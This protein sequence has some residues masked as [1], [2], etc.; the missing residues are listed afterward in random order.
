MST[1]RGKKATDA[2]HPAHRAKRGPAASALVATQRRKKIDSLSAVPPSHLLAVRR[3]KNARRQAGSAQRR[4]RPGD[5]TLQRAGGVDDALTM[6]LLKWPLREL[7]LFSRLVLAV[8]ER[9]DPL[10]FEEARFAHDTEVA[11]RDGTVSFARFYREVQDGA[12]QEAPPDEPP[13]QRAER[14]AHYRETLRGCL[15]VAL[16]RDC[17]VQRFVMAQ[18][19][20]HYLALLY[21]PPGRERANAFLD[22]LAE[23]VAAYLAGAQPVRA[24]AEYA[25]ACWRDA[26]LLSRDAEE[27]EG[28]LRAQAEMGGAEEEEQTYHT[29][30]VNKHG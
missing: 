12:E 17:R 11:T 20:V 28:A 3:L 10:A 1:K 18:H 27:W 14:A 25:V 24:V 26:F 16:A 4:R 5:D 9:R 7:T 21:T 15:M 2:G 29:F 30:V 19:D 23:P 6:V 8:V 22:A 13:H